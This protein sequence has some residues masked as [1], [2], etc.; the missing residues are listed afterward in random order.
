MITNAD[1]LVIKNQGVRGK[2]SVFTIDSVIEPDRIYLSGNWTSRKTYIESN[3]PGE[4]IV[5]FLGSQSY[6]YFES[7][8]QGPLLLKITLDGFPVSPVVSGNDIHHRA[9]QSYLFITNVAKLYQLTNKQLNYGRHEL[10]ISVPK[11]V[12]FYSLSFPEQ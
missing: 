10:M 9:D 11:G 5:N 3:A 4:I 8:S 12:K 7:L 2:P 6:A 1:Y